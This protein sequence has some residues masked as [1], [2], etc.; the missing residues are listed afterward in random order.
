[1]LS[2]ALFIKLGQNINRCLSC[3]IKAQYYLIFTLSQKSR[4]SIEMTLTLKMP[5]WYF[6]LLFRKLN[7]FTSINFQE[8]FEKRKKP[9]LPKTMTY[10]LLPE[11]SLVELESQSYH[12]FTSKIRKH[13]RFFQRHQSFSDKP[14]LLPEVNKAPTKRTEHFTEQH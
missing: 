4:G 1:M 11:V 13:C 12:Q 3:H 8:T 7:A 2:Q 6:Q 10:F 9:S 5:F 14:C